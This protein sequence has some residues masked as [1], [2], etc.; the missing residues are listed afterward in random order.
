[1]P[2]ELPLKGARLMMAAISSS[3]SPQG[4][5]TGLI[6]CQQNKAR[7]LS[8]SRLV[9]FM[10]QKDNKYAGRIPEDHSEGF[11]T[12]SLHTEALWAI[13]VSLHV[14]RIE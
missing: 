12:T 10:R 2:K 14:V 9:R 8:V 13:K 7:R 6:T 5:F 1:M 11:G 3:S 4:V